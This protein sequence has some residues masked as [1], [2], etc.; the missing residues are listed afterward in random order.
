MLLLTKWGLVFHVR[1]YDIRLINALMIL[2]G[3]LFAERC[4]SYTK[5]KQAVCTY[6]VCSSVSVS[7]TS[8]VLL[9][10]PVFL[11]IKYVVQCSTL[12]YRILPCRR[13]AATT[14]AA[15]NGLQLAITLRQEWDFNF[16]YEFKAVMTTISL[17]RVRHICTCT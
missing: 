14:A 2:I 17:Q 15:K 4:S 8:T 7:V 1:M 11:V 16:F 6:V 13:E 3:I 10:L 12:A 5:L 9:P